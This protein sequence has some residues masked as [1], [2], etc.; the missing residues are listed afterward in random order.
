MSLR[1]VGYFVEG[2]GCHFSWHKESSL[3]FQTHVSF[4]ASTIFWS[5]HF[6][7]IFESTDVSPVGGVALL[8]W[9]NSSVRLPISGWSST[10]MIR[11]SRNS[12]KRQ[13]AKKACLASGSQTLQDQ[14]KTNHVVQCQ[15]LVRWNEENMLQQKYS[16]LHGT[17]Y[18][19]LLLPPSPVPKASYW[20]NHR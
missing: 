7:W 18:L 20:L 9:P 6:V 13:K 10:F 11:T 5:T 14:F 16:S 2:T 19:R 1:E 12:C 3:H 17:L 8:S 4:S 15:F